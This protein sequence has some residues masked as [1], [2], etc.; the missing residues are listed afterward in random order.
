VI[1]PAAR[2]SVKRSCSSTVPTSSR[3]QSEPLGFVAEFFRLRLWQFE[4]QLHEST[5]ARATPSNTRLHSTAAGA[6]S[7]GRPEIRRSY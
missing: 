2:S 6:M 3:R 1:C 7:S 5:V 4:G